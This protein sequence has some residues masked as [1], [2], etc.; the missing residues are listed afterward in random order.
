MIQCKINSYS[1]EASILLVLFVVG[2]STKRVFASNS[3]K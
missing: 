1:R 3:N 2:K